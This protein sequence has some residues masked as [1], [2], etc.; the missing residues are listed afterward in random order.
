MVSFSCRGLPSSSSASSVAARADSP[1]SKIPHRKFPEPK[2]WGGA[3]QTPRE[4]SR[5]SFCPPGAPFRRLRITCRTRLDRGVPVLG[6]GNGRS[7]P[8]DRIGYS[9]LGPLITYQQRIGRIRCAHDR[10]ARDKVLMHM[11]ILGLCDLA[12]TLDTHQELVRAQLDVFGHRGVG[13]N[14]DA[15]DRTA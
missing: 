13:E 10:E 15:S 9:R 2:K 7:Y 12:D 14:V 5:S 3:R 11:H 4:P 8:F 6:M 1:I